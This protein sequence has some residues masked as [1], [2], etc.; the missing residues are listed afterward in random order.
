MTN[1]RTR[2]HKLTVDEE[3][4]EAMFAARGTYLAAG[5]EDP[6]VGVARILEERLGL[7]LT[8]PANAN[9]AIIVNDED[10]SFLAPDP[11]TGTFTT[12]SSLLAIYEDVPPDWATWTGEIPSRLGMLLWKIGNLMKSI[13][14]NERFPR[15]MAA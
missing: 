2:L 6:W 13:G 4:R 3:T 7:D 10:F 15:P 11:E 12:I 8:D 9:V 14:W 5:R 1:R